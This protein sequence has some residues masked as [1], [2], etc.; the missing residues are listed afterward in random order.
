MDIT[1]CGTV[2]EHEQTQ[3]N[4]THETQ[5]SRIWEQRGNVKVNDWH[6]IRFK[7]EPN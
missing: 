3:H 5:C 4:Q 6:Y 1:W 2:Y 7:I